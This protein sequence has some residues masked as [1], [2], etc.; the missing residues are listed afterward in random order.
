MT[1]TVRSRVA[2]IDRLLHAHAGGLELR[3]HAGDRVRVRY[4]GM[5]VGC[6]FKAVTAEAT[7]RPL[8]LELADVSVVEIEGGRISEEAQERL[9]AALGHQQCPANSAVAVGT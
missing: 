1:V 6:P 4:T 5:C 7:V 8:L 9:R 2:Q 3:E